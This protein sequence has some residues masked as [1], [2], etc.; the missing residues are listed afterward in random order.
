MISREGNNLWRLATWYVSQPVPPFDIATFGAIFDALRTKKKTHWPVRS[1]DVRP[2]NVTS[3]I[4]DFLRT[5]QAQILHDTVD[6]MEWVFYTP[7]IAICYKC[8]KDFD[9][10]WDGWDDIKCPHCDEWLTG[11]KL[12]LNKPV[13]PGEK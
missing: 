5:F 1:W 9:G 2:E 8:K 12:K 6:D 10:V 7:F 11:K 13:I 3:N 4:A